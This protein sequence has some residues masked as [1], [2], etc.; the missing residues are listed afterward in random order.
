VKPKLLKAALY[1][2]GLACL[3]IFL[4]VRAGTQYL[5]GFFTINEMDDQARQYYV[6]E[7]GRKFLYGHLYES[8]W[9]T[10]FRQPFYIEA[11]EYEPP[12]QDVEKAEVLVFGDSFFRS[13]RQR[14]V[15]KRLADSLGI[16]V[17]IKRTNDI[18][19]LAMLEKM[20]YQKGAPKYL[21][22][23]SVER[24][25][26][27][28]L[29]LL[30][31]DSL[32]QRPPIYQRVYKQL[33]QLLFLDDPDRRYSYVIQHLK[34]LNALLTAVNSFN[35]DHFGYISSHT[36]VYSYDPPVLFYHQTVNDEETS[37]YYSFTDE[38]IELF[39]DNAEQLRQQL[40]AQYN[41]ELVFMPIPNKYTIYHR[42]VNNDAYNQLL[43]RLYD[44]LEKR[45]VKV[46][47]LYEPFR[48]SPKML[49]Y[50]TDTHWNRDG[51]SLALKELI[52]TLFP[53][54]GM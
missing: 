21:V 36:P 12:G 32:A 50:P 5:P 14:S 28:R 52:K 42:L 38:E 45:G 44:G 40:K 30:F 15:P 22:H 19:P 31:N 53:P 43:P 13:W 20:G 18:S 24:F 54:G 8:N 33:I 49:Y 11:E 17:F 6:D 1:L 10:H 25:V 27:R 16:P 9:I 34:G 47:R 48:Q 39:C 41:L 51:V 7:S 3:A 35:F 2:F 37:F 26:P 46:V 4:I 29:K 23:E